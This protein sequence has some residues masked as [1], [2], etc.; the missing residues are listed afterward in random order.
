MRTY[1]TR[2]DGRAKIDGSPDVV[3]V[4]G[5]G[6][7]Y[8]REHA[9]FVAKIP[10]CGVR[11]LPAGELIIGFLSRDGGINSIYALCVADRG[12]ARSP[13]DH[14]EEATQ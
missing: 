12:R 1:S 6:G 8:L 14:D 11:G 4:C 13:A 9:D 10:S 3:E 2:I 7:E 5:G